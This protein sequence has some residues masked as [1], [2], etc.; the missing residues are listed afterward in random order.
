MIEDEETR[1]NYFARQQAEFGYISEKNVAVQNALMEGE[2]IGE[3]RGLEKGLEK[4]RSE[5]EKIG[6][7]KG[8]NAKAIEVARAMLSHNDALDYIALISGLTVEEVKKLK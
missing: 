7:E 6:I 8:A 1:N 3:A 5:G 2:K 4:G